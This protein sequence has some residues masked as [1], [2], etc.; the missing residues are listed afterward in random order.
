MS[1]RVWLSAAVLV[2]TYSG[3]ARAT[4]HGQANASGQQAASPAP[5]GDA[6]NG[7]KLFAADGCYQCH[8]Y[9]GQG[10][11]GTGPRLAPNPIPYVQLSRYV[12]APTGQMPLYTSK[13]L[14]DAELADIYAYLR[15]R[16]LPP[17]L[18]SI[19][20]PR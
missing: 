8:G 14:S 4:L 3:A 15:S 19:A 18:D 17:P 1:G 7:R 13:V 2:A 10:A 6:E 20:L 11:G 9:E 5:A 16:P 12:R